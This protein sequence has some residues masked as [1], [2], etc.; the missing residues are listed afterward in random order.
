MKIGNLV[1]IQESPA[2][3]SQDRGKLA[4]IIATR[5]C[6]HGLVCKLHF[7]N[8]D[9]RFDEYHEGRLDVINEIN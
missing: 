9:F 8:N 6:D 1:K 3:I 4:I 7:F 5:T 2:N